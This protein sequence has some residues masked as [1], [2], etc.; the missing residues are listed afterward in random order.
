[1]NNSRAGPSRKRSR[2]RS[3]TNNNNTARSTRRRRASTAAATNSLASLRQFVRNHQPGAPTIDDV[4]PIVMARRHLWPIRERGAFA[5]AVAA[6]NKLPC[7]GLVHKAALLA[8]DIVLAIASNAAGRPYRR[9]LAE[10]RR[11][12]GVNFRQ[13]T[14]DNNLIYVWAGRLQGRI[15]HIP[16]L[17]HPLYANHFV[18]FEGAEPL[19]FEV[20]LL[21]H[22]RNGN[23]VH[24]RTRGAFVMR[25][26]CPDG[27]TCQIAA[28]V[29][30]KV[31]VGDR[32]LRNV[33]VVFWPAN[34]RRFVVSDDLAR[35]PER[36]VLDKYEE[37]VQSLL[38]NP[39]EYGYDR[40]IE[41]VV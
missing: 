8:R 21:K 19:V 16:H 23:G 17:Q 41:L 33:K 31:R 22:A 20:D 40:I 9:R 28:D 34:G 6:N 39:T 11:I 5:E 30:V 36:P 32:G 2:A 1:M 10:I 18:E 12:R 24:P 3:H 25:L 15:M 37:L 27:T 26:R 38:G 13:K 29:A 7:L 14:I 35:V 4:L